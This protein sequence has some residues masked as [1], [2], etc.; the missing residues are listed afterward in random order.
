[1]MENEK[2]VNGFCYVLSHK[3]LNLKMYYGSTEDIPDRWENHISNCNNPNCEKYNYQVY[4]YIREHG[5]IQNW[6]IDTI[7]EGEDYKDFE[8][9]TIEDTFDDNLNYEIPYRDEEHRREREKARYKKYNVKNKYKIT[10]KFCSSIVSKR[11]ISQHYKSLK[12]QEAQ[13]NN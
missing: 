6:K 13:Q 1:M 7:Y 5:G 8:S 2:K 11:S 3:S 10:C 9:H 12:C 4:K